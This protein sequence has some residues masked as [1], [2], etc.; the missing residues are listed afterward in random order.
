MGWGTSFDA[1]IYIKKQCFESKEQVKLEI[2]EC[3]SEIEEIK[4]HLF[5]YVYATPKDIVNN[6][7]DDIIMTLKVMF[8]D[9]I[10]YLEELII[11]LEKLYLLEENFDTRVSG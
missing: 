11:K 4:K 9:Q 2:E 7:D 3:Q 6:E 1:N 8:N 10:E 5:G